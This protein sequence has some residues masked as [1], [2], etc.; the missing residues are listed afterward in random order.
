MSDSLIS[1]LF[2]ERCERIA[3]VSEW[4]NHRVFE[5]IADSR[6]FGQK[7][8]DSLRKSMS[9]FPALLVNEY[10]MTVNSTIQY[11]LKYSLQ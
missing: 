10:N 11:S 9:E 7:T 2:G 4:V 1:L 6:I 8:S 5:R 3:Q